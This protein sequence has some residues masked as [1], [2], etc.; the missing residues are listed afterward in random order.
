MGVSRS[1]SRVPNR[2]PAFSPGDGVSVSISARALLEEQGGTIWVET[3][4]GV[5]TTF[6]FSLPLAESVAPRASSR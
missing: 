2:A 3:E 5:G 6:F 4:M 1:L